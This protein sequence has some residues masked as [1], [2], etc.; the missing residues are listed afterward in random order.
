MYVRT[1]VST[2]VHTYM[3]TYIRVGFKY[4]FL[5][6]Y[7]RLV[8]SWCIWIG[9]H[10]RACICIWSVLYLKRYLHIQWKTHTN[11]HFMNKKW[12]TVWH[13]LAQESM[14]NVFMPVVWSTGAGST[15]KIGLQSRWSNIIIS[16]NELMGSQWILSIIIKVGI[17]IQRILLSPA[18]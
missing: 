2:Y 16:I 15:E 3:P 17:Q 11:Y 9:N 12:N 8:R 13:K 4:V 1:Y 14:Q 18:V 10:E 7:Q 6:E 5:F